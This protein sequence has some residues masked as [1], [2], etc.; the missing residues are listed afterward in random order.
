[1]AENKTN[2]TLSTE[3]LAKSKERLPS[4][5]LRKHKKIAT[6]LSRHLL[7]I[8]LEVDTNIPYLEREKSANSN[9]PC[10]GVSET[11]RADFLQWNKIRWI[12]HDCFV[13]LYQLHL[14]Q[15]I[16]PLQSKQSTKILLVFST[17]SSNQTSNEWNFIY[18]PQGKNEVDVLTI[19]SSTTMFARQ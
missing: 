9:F 13:L 2:S 7:R 14:G 5:S 6:S 15:N 4:T 16:W 10:T 1:M 3:L 17:T 8:A 11:G 12:N 19:A 18:T